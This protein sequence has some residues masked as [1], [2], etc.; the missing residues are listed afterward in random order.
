MTVFRFCHHIYKTSR[1]AFFLK[2]ETKEL[3]TD[4]EIHWI[5]RAIGIEWGKGFFG[6]LITE[7]AKKVKE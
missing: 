3:I 4:P 7:P 2:R 1:I 5:R 6:L